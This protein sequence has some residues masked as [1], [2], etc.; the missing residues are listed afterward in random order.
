MSTFMISSTKIKQELIS[1]RPSKCGVVLRNWVFC[2]WWN[3]LYN[4]LPT[5]NVRWPVTAQWVG[6]VALWTIYTLGCKLAQIIAEL[7]LTLGKPLSEERGMSVFYFFCLGAP[8]SVGGLL[9]VGSLERHVTNTPT[10]LPN[11][12]TASRRPADVFLNEILQ[13]ST[14]CGLTLPLPDLPVNYATVVLR[15]QT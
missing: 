10:C 2:H 13:L 11:D 15:T 7:T 6:V 4:R 8:S 14:L 9:Y 1:T 12:L 5:P 3:T